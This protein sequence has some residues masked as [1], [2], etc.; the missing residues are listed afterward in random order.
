M[1]YCISLFLLA[2]FVH[3]V[4][5]QSLIK[6]QIPVSG[7]TNTY[8]VIIGV[9][10][11]LDTDIRQLQFANR[12]AAIFA[13]FLMSASGG[14]V[15]KENIT[16]LIDENATWGAINNAITKLKYQ[17]NKNDNV[18]FYFSGHGALE[19]ET[20]YNHG[21]LICYN[22]S[23]T[24][25]KNMGVSI[26]W[27]NEMANTLAVE[28]NANV[29]MITD[30]CHSGRMAINKFKGSALAGEELMITKQREIRMASCKP[31]ET[32]IE[33]KDWG[34]GRGVFS[35]HLVNGLQ[36]D[37]ADADKNG[38]VTVAELKAYLENA[39]KNDKV[40][41]NDGDIQTPVIVTKGPPDFKL[42][43]VVKS[44]T[45]KIKQT[46]ADDSVL[47]AMI[48]NAAN[49]FETEGPADPEE[50]FFSLLKKENLEWVT[51]LKPDSLSAGAI[52]FAIV[53]EL[54]KR[55]LTE[56][57]LAKLKELTR[58][59]KND[60]EK[61]QRFNVS[62]ANIIIDRGLAII[63]QYKKGD[64]AELE[65]RRYYNIYSSG[66]DVYPKMFAAA[67]KLSQGDQYSSN[68]SSIFLHYFTG[69]ALRLKIPI[70]ADPKPL[71]EQ[72]LAEQKKA[73]ALEEYA[74]YIYNELGILYQYKKN[75]ADAEKHFIKAT[76]I[77]SDW[78][79]PYSNLCGL[80]T[81]EGKYEKAMLACRQADS[82]DKAPDSLKAGL[83]S[84]S[85]NQGFLN[86][87]TKNQLLAEEFYHHAIDIN[88]RHFLPFER[89][90][91]VNMNITDYALAD[92][93]FY[94]ADLRKKGFHF[95]GNE[96]D[97]DFIGQ[98]APPPVFRSCNVDTSGLLPRDIFA[99]F[100][101]GVQQYRDSNYTEALGSLKKV[102]AQDK[103]NPLA[104]HYLGKLFFDQQKWEE[105]ELMFNL[106]MKYA[107]N[108]DRFEHYVDS[109]KQSFKYTYDHDCY[110]EFFK[111]NY[112][113]GIEDYF[114]AGTLYENWK[115]VDEAELYFKSIIRINSQDIGGYLK[116]WQL[117]EK[118]GRYT[119][120][121]QKI[122]DYGNINKRQS[123]EELNAFYRRTIKKFPDDSMW[124]YRLGLLLYNRASLHYPVYELGEVPYLDSIVW[125]PMLNKELFIDVDIY[126]NLAETDS[127]L[128]SDRLVTGS[129]I[130]ITT[131]DKRYMESTRGKLF[132]PRKD[133]IM[134]LKRAAELLSEKET[135]ADINFKIGNMYLWAGS[136]KQAYPY[137]EKS[138]LL[139]PDNASARLTLVDIYKA[140]YKNRSAFNQLNY[141][142][143]SNLINFQKRLLF[144]QFNIHAGQFEKANNLLDKAEAIYPYPV[145]E[146]TDLRGRL[147][148][149]ADNLKKAIAFYEN[150]IQ[151][152][153]AGTT[154]DYTTIKE[155]RDG[156]ITE[157]MVKIDS[158]RMQAYTLARL[159]AKNSKP[160]EAFKWL[161]TAIN[162]GFNYSF[163]LQNDPYM[164]SLRKTTKWQILTGSISIKKYPANYAFN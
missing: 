135:L 62:V 12:D 153:T 163:V 73:L 51:D 5:A 137:F 123:E 49:L 155:P 48:I 53:N 18:F 112:Y 82:L 127:L 47:N 10:K 79:I 151:S 33:K 16:L 126:N 28:N 31:E 110:A 14:S 89:L 117:Y 63:L 23:T 148:M 131:L 102:I 136:K 141:L 76:R 3:L 42:A 120:A 149:L 138:L 1:K 2:F 45:V 87:K 80:Y 72:A 105:A 140:L 88:S 144:A 96:W 116:L 164:V 9:A 101:L 147:N 94:E 71:I 161:E 93:F 68:I 157:R 25:F 113:D 84:I 37:L 35:Y 64:E 11:Y 85:I 46:V 133:G 22:T 160:G 59:L 132:E 97:D 21:Y 50:Y 118:Q 43:T 150:Y 7:K 26:V 122:K 34:G 40:L 99:F 81:A 100:T 32:S 159:Y 74:A 119:E 4:S 162:F 41:K 142:Y 98:G 146:I 156:K 124:N 109:V 69:V 107:L 78:A 67:L 36:G 61:L 24:A 75:Y 60:D 17:C 92:S 128:I 29:I 145:P 13:D 38:I 6:S 114:L 106:S 57:Q 56:S 30:A 83:Q 111:E 8:A 15:P 154:S 65:R 158:R 129:P 134:Y 58:Q 44:E 104:F 143:D 54:E 70:T 91:Y 115:H 39:M 90:G 95:F 152:D 121:E 108:R 125:F 86:E 139:I 55:R 52:A 27:L 19:N 130:T 103:T 66:Y 77:S 20:M